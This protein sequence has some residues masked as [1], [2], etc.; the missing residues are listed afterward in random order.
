[1]CACACVHVPFE[2][3]AHC[4]LSFVATPPSTGPEAWDWGELQIQEWL[5]QFFLQVIQKEHPVWGE[6]V[7]LT[8]RERA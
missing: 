3:K 4:T 2:P 7:M 8:S 1:M 5:S 6:G